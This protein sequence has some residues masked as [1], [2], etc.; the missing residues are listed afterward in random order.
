MYLCACVYA[1]V[2]V[3]ECALRVSCY[4]L[5]FLKLFLGVLF[6]PGVYALS[7]CIF[8]SPKPPCNAVWV[9]FPGVLTIQSDALPSCPMSLHLWASMKLLRGS[10]FNE[11]GLI[12]WGVVLGS[13]GGRVSVGILRDMT[14]LM[15]RANFFVVV[16]TAMNNNPFFPPT[17]SCLWEQLWSP[18]LG[19]SPT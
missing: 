2:C 14:A 12:A 11:T 6:G 8:W 13:S 9:L 5:S 1:C 15:C 7:S 10:R 4:I 3:Q 16:K 18:A 17:C 19:F